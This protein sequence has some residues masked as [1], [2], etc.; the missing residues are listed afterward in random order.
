MALAGAV[1]PS[2]G[3]TG[4]DPLPITLTWLLAMLSFPQAVELRASL[5]YWLLATRLLQCSS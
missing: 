1:V 2:E 3:L 4:K 5:P